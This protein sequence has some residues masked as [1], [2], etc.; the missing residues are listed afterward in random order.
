ME[1]M[2][3]PHTPH[4]PEPVTAAAVPAPTMLG[5]Y[6][7]FDL[8]TRLALLGLGLIHLAAGLAPVAAVAPATLVG[9][10]LVATLLSLAGAIPAVRR[11]LAARGLWRR[12]SPGEQLV[13]TFLV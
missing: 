7:W 10:Y 8:A 4:D 2:G 12:P 3:T 6:A 11:T 13:L 9:G 1:A 5:G